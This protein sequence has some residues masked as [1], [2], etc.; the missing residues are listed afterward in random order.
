MQNVQ[1]KIDNVQIKMESKID[2]AHSNMEIKI[3][4][5]DKNMQNV[6]GNLESLR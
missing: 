4:A 2:N 3:E 1:S 6:Q 5:L